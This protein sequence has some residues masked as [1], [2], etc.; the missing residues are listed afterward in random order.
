MMAD[1]C[2]V[3]SV[4]SV[5]IPGILAMAGWRAWLLVGIGL[6]PLAARADDDLESLFESRVRPT[7]VQTCFRCHGGERTAQGL[8]VDSREALLKGGK[9]GPAIVPGKPEQSLLLAAIEYRDDA[10]FQMPPDGKL[11]SETIGAIEAWIK[12]GAP[13]PEAKPGTP[14]FAHA[15]HWAYQ[16]VKAVE[17]PADQTCPLQHPIDQFVAAGWKERN[18]HRV[19]EADRR[20]L[21]RRLYFDLIGLPPA[22]QEIDEFLGDS[23]ADAWEK[24]IERLLASPHYGERWGR[25][26]MDVVRYA[27]T[28]GDNADY[29][30]PEA[31]LYR[32]YIIDSFNADKPYDEFVR[33]QVAGDLLATQTA[34]GGGSREKFA[35]QTIAT[36]FLALSRRYATAPY[37]LWHLTLEDTIDT[38]GRAFLGQTFKCARCHDHKFDPVTQEDY[39]A[40]YGIFAGT[41][42]PWAGGEEYASKQFGRQD[43][44]PLIRPAESASL[45]GAHAQHVA[46][47]E[48]QIKSLDANAD[49]DKIAKLKGELRDVLRTSVPAGVPC[50]YAVRDGSPADVPLQQKGDPAQPGLSVPR[51]MPAFLCSDLQESIPAGQSG[52]LQLA[53]WLTL[54]Q[55]PLTARVIVNRLWH[56]HFG[57]G[58]V[59]TP[60]NFGTRGDA[61][62]HPELLDWLARRFVQRGWSIK[63]MHRL[64]LTSQVWRMSSDHDEQNAAVDPENRFYWRFDRCRLDAEAIRDALLAVA[65]G[66]DLARPAEH[67]FP[68]IKTW[69]W[70]QHKPFKDVYPSSHRSVYLMTQ[71]IQRHPFLT[72]F[73]GP[74][75]NTTTEKRTS[76]VVPLQAL[77]W[78]NSPLV[79]EEAERFAR[80]LIS[81]GDAPA[82]V[83]RAFE[84]AYGRPPSSAETERFVSYVSRYHEELLRSGGDE[85]RAELET[86]TSLARVVLSSNEFVY[87]D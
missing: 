39:Y 27:D 75:T 17:P 72:L 42:F 1:A 3:V 15:A 76:S 16:P 84:L 22:P 73:D 46:E 68:D 65:G 83:R 77:F 6:I 86:W 23:S 31:R 45:L 59:A 66:L 51:R 54:P 50:A 43:F 10:A 80:I 87:I 63:D 13:W 58:L 28:A 47:L 74:D 24:L 60:S 69:T 21:I 49:K 26:W 81:A 19:K 29:P 9:N 52:R 8:R 71:R 37:E 78:M 62:T 56:A 44:A 79:R 38:V 2:H 35:E 14:S 67:P 11:P 55:H 34:A 41:Q 4:R 33:E 5:L 48:Q 61:P 18:L 40:L 12:N 53:R 36:G 57:K 30:V 70:T 7:L 64:I 85:T 25:Q 20:V 32:D 82:R